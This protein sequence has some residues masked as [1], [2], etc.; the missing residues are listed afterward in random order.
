VPRDKD[1]E[2]LKVKYSAKNRAPPVSLCKRGGRCIE[3]ILGAGSTPLEQFLIKR[4]LMGPCWVRIDA[5]V[6]RDSKVSWCVLEV[7]VSD[8]KKITVARDC[9]YSAPPL[10]CTTLSVKTAVNPKSHQH[11]IVAVAALTHR[12]V[13]VDGATPDGGRG[14]DARLFQ[15]S[16]EKQEAGS[17]RWT[18]VAA[19]PLGS[20]IAGAQ[21]V[22]L[23]P[24]L[25]RDLHGELKKPTH[26]FL[27][28]RGT[29]T[30]APNERALISV[31]LARL[32]RDDPD[33]LCGHNILGFE[34]DVLLA[35]AL[36]LKVGNAWSKV[37]DSAWF[38]SISQLEV[39]STASSRCCT[40]CVAA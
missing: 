21:D 28:D 8:A 17:R 33:V 18:C 23:D 26:G 12:G 20:E 9:P 19:R 2:Y 5:P 36:A 10:V 11:E 24:K 31:L 6:Q 27:A 32:Q 22:P 34:L 1:T 4:K 7:E 38:P 13:A 35:R 15:H 40:A 14:E 3:K 37:S 30:V 25:P 39:A 16:V 29:V